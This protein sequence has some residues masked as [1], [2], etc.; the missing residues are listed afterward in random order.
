MICLS[1]IAILMFCV[2]NVATASMNKYSTTFHNNARHTGGYIPMMREH[3]SNGILNWKYATEGIVTSSAT[4]NGIVYI[5]SL[6]GNVYALDAN[7]GA[8]VW[9]YKTE[10]FW[11]SSPTVA[12]GIVYVGSS[13]HNIYALNAKT[14]AKV[15]N[16]TTDFLVF[17][18]PT[19]ANGIVYVGS[20]DHNVY[21]LNANT[22]TK[23]WSYATGDGVLSSPTVANGIG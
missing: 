17:S 2:P 19:V 10:Y 21:A 16:Y 14:G 12:N 9:S 4:P 23:M 20:Y 5:G 7:T 3:T 22:G 11:P 6:D 15:W 8:K 18:S 13:D 1:I